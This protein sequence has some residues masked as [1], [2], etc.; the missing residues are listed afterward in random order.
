MAHPSTRPRDRTGEATELERADRRKRGL[1]RDC[2]RRSKTVL[3]SRCNA[4]IESAATRYRGQQRPGR[5]SRI[6]EDLKDLT[7]AIDAI[8]V[9]HRALLIVGEMTL[10][11]RDRREALA[12]PLAQVNLARRFCAEVLRRHDVM[13]EALEKLEAEDAG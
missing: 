12:E 4:A 5:M 1:C 3:C 10:S 2:P 8:T 7:C 11:S 9:A 13:Y 6:T